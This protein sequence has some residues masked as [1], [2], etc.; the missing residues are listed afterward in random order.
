MSPAYIDKQSIATQLPMSEAIPLMESMFRDLANG[1]ILQPLRSLMWLPDNRGILGMMPAY[2][3]APESGDSII[4][5]KL[6]TIFHANHAA[7][8]PSH[9]GVI[10][11]FDG[12]NGSPL[13]L[14]D[15]EEITA[16]RTAAA[17]AVATNLLATR[18]ASTLA[19][20]GT[21]EQA[22]RHLESISLVRPIKQINI[23]G[24]NK[25]KA[26]QLAAKSAEQ[27][28]AKAANQP[29]T[30]SKTGTRTIPNPTIT[31]SD[32]PQQAAKNADIICTVTASSQPILQGK[33][34]APGAHLNV[35]GSC[36]PN[37]REVDSDTIANAK[38]FTDK[39]ES[40]FNEAGDFLIPKKEGRISE[41]AVLA[42]IGEILTAAKPGRQH[43]T[44]I[45][46]FKSLGIAAE[47]LYSAYHIYKKIRKI[48]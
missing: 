24:R 26:E 30:E 41:S 29:T 38:I 31:L 18:E 43:P 5:I 33:W 12:A 17:S 27:L 47:D 13:M 9:Q 20:L 23:W 32:T 21:G 10:I 15:A 3:N 11:L 6:I 42:E 40:L 7:G 48:P 8:Y 36:T 2:A 16:I 37:A 28:A 39:Y 4:G 34:I 44:D 45:T 1:Q 35:I 25:R 22:Q 14:F 19:I 46:L